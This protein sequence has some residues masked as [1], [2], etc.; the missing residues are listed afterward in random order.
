MGETT[1]PLHKRINIHRTSKSGCENII[2]HFSGPCKGHTFSI[3]VLEK[4]EGDGYNSLNEV[5][6]AK[7]R[8][9]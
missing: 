1:L 5:D 7:R 4:F 8:I 3:Q 6:D 9:R 2:S